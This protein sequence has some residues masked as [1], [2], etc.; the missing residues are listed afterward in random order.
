MFHEPSGTAAKS[1]I[2]ARF[3]SNDCRR[4]VATLAARWRWGGH[5]AAIVVP[6]AEFGRERA[7]VS[8]CVSACVCVNVCVCV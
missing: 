6:A 8:V 1:G 2:F 4:A 7:V 3:H 5:S